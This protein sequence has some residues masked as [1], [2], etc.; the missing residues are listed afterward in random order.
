MSS[1]ICQKTFSNKSRILYSLLQ[2]QLVRIFPCPSDKALFHRNTFFFYQSSWCVPAVLGGNN[3][4]V[5]KWSPPHCWENKNIWTT[6][7]GQHV[8]SD[9][10]A[11]L[12][13]WSDISPGLCVWWPPSPSWACRMQLG[14]LQWHHSLGEQRSG[15]EHCP[16]EM[17]LSSD[18]VG[19]TYHT[20]SATKG[21]HRAKT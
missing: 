12:P 13:C 1:T 19:P 18:T 14:Q 4:G 3:I 7:T 15:W 21:T 8:A 2:I 9:L 5:L 20:N 17:Q 11:A 16:K 6:H 10:P